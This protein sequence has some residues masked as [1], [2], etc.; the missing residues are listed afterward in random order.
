M[1]SANIFS[2]LLFKS[3]EIKSTA[4]YFIDFSEKY[5]PLSSF[6]FYPFSFGCCN[7]TDYSF[8]NAKGALAGQI[9][10]DG[11]AIHVT[12]NNQSVTLSGELKICVERAASIPLM[13]E[14][15]DT[16]D[17]AIY[18]NVTQ[19]FVPVEVI[20][21][22]DNEARLAYFVSGFHCSRI[23]RPMPFADQS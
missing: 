8:R 10:G 6:S 13:N 23:Y 18:N 15:Y 9:I 19:S 20:T 22:E 12:S 16:L 5:L 1:S 7:S 17:F 2:N 11:V 21:T 3:R 14:L 4:T